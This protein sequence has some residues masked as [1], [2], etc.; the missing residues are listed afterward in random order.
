MKNFRS[1]VTEGDKEAYKK[2]F[3]AK[4]KKYG[5]DSPE[6]LSDADKKK[7]F[8]E[9]DKEWNSDDEEGKDGMKEYIK[10]DGV[11]RRC[12]GG[13]GRKTKKVMPEED[14]EEE[15]E[16][17]H[18][19]KMSSFKTFLEAVDKHMVTELKLYIENDGDLYK[20]RLIPIVKNIQKKMKSG[21][22]DHKQAPK[23]WMYLVTDGAKKYAKEFPGVKF[24]KQE[25]EAVAQEFADDYRDEL[26]AQD[27]EMF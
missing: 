27:G 4:L 3:D 18:K 10:H 23:L 1:F 22:Y 7:F 20:Q 14:E 13:D 26:E 25:K 15:I 17:D 24:N 8:N 12:A 11:R 2:F 21:K 9:I 16:E 6:D 19:T 5:V